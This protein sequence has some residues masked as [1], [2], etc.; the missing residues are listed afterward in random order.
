MD[1][2]ETKNLLT[3]FY[4]IVVE[5]ESQKPIIIGKNGNTIKKLGILIRA[6]LSEVYDCKL[7][8]QSFVKV[9]KNWRDNNEIIKDLGYKK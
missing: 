6:K 5:K 1:Y 2:D 4:S 8:L 7:F 9:K 3:I